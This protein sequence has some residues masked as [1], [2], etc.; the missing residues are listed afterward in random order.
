MT[1]RERVANR[2]GGSVHASVRKD[3]EGIAA[4][5]DALIAALQAAQA[6]A[7]EPQ[8]IPVSERLPE[9]PGQVIVYGDAQGVRPM[10]AAAV[11]SCVPLLEERER[12][13]VTHWMPLPPA[14]VF[15]PQPKGTP[16]AYVKPQQLETLRRNGVAM[17]DASDKA[18]G[19]CT[20]PI[21]GDVQAP[22]PGAEAG[23]LRNYWADQMQKKADAD[24]AR[25]CLQ[26]VSYYVWSAFIYAGV[27]QKKAS[28]GMTHPW[29]E[30]DDSGEALAG[31]APAEPT[32]EMVKAGIHEWKCAP[33][34][35]SGED[36][37]KTIYAAMRAVAP[38]VQALAPSPLTDARVD[39]LSREMVKGG[40]S[41]N[42][43]CRAI[44]R[45]VVESLQAPAVGAKPAAW[46]DDFGNVFPLGAVKSAGS[47]RDEHQRNWTPLYTSAPAAWAEPVAWTTDFDLENVR[48]GFAAQLTGRS[49]RVE[50][51]FP[52]KQVVYLYAAGSQARPKEV[53]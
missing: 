20:A 28:K 3:L 7:A 51:A 22:A 46:M 1:F 39:D 26:P 37:V 38:N 36:I 52:T 53:E 23:E 29:G 44:E 10:E 42:W 9:P 17:L 18:V 49:M 34:S 4:E 41:V 15:N 24:K 50:P 31:A 12:G 25:G 48:T 2:L 21:Y 45:E 8:W 35:I 40:K 43:L 47:W 33:A 16:L 27:G 13:W 19:F 32:P 5:A 30:V 6:P 11:A 14:P